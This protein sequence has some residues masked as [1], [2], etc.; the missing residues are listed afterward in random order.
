MT[1]RT[2]GTSDTTS[3]RVFLQHAVAG[4]GASAAVA[5]GRTTAAGAE[6]A[7]DQAAAT[8]ITPIR[9]P[10]EFAASASA[11]PKTFTFPMTGA[12][13]FARACKEEGVA[14][15]FTCP[16]NYPVI[17]AIASAGIPAFG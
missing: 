12:Q 10:A 3:R 14:A 16:G 5:L 9:V 11:G 15:L 13:V 8:G 7:A 6:G 1:K 4:A 2:T 17:H